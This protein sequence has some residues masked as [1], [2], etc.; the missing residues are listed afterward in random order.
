MP[1][2]CLTNAGNVHMHTNRRAGLRGHVREP[3]TR[4]PVIARPSRSRRPIPSAGSSRKPEPGHVR[5]R[6]ESAH[7]LRAKFSI[8]RI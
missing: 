7:S 6:L 8:P 4:D 2:G 3:L 1:A 5:M